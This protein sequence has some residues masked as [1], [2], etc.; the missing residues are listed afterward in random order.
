MIQTTNKYIMLDGDCVMENKPKS[1][2]QSMYVGSQGRSPGFSDIWVKTWKM[3]G[4][5]KSVP[6]RL[7]LRN[8]VRL[9]L[10]ILTKGVFFPLNSREWKGRG[11]IE[12]EAS[13]GCILHAP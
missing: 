3:T 4:S 9:L 11:E 8:I 13:I 6:N 7:L 2:K 10:L 5:Q 12:K 1:E